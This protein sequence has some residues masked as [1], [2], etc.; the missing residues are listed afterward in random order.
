M[1]RAE[2]EGVNIGNLGLH[3]F[4]ITKTKRFTK[5]FEEKELE[6]HSRT[7]LHS[8]HNARGGGDELDVALEKFVL[9]L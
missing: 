1:K 7:L 2:K 9:N 4:V 6:E 8:Y 5:N 3:P